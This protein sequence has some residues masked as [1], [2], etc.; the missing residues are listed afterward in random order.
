LRAVRRDR[1]DLIHLTTPGPVGLAA[2]F[3]A[4]QAGLTMVVGTFH[5]DLAAYTAMLSGSTRLAALMREFTFRLHRIR[6]ADD[7]A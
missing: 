4:R 3:V 1:I 7:P 2:L 5:T 6:P